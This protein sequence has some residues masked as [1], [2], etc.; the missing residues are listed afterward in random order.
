MATPPI[1]NTVRYEMNA[2]NQF[3]LCRSCRNHLGAL[4]SNCYGQVSSLSLFSFTI[5]TSILDSVLELAFDGLV[6]LTADNVRTD[7][8][9]TSLYDMPAVNVYCN[10]CN[11]RVGGR[12]GPDAVLGWNPRVA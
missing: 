3:M 8:T 9:P 2:E 6:C 4:G 1:P 10:G 5:R 12:I 11:T 7:E